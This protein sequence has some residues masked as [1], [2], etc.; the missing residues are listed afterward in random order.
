MCSNGV[1]QIRDYEEVSV[2]KRTIVLCQCGQITVLGWKTCLKP[3]THCEVK[4]TL[5][6]NE[7]Y[8]SV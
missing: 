2:V 1:H 6:V 4:G 8:L 5:Y 3:V 7:T